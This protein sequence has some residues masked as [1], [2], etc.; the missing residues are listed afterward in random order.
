MS[1]SR[2]SSRDLLKSKDLAPKP[3]TTA[4]LEEILWGLARALQSPGKWFEVL[5]D[6]ELPLLI[7]ASGSVHVLDS[8]L[9]M[10]E[11]QWSVF[12]FGGKL[13]GVCCLALE[14]N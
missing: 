8:L 12:G 10:Y 2:V 5:G 1:W 11:R 4:Y 6:V 7:D 3:L 13:S 14:A 9:T